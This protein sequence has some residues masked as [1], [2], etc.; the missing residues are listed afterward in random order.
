MKADRFAVPGASSTRFSPGAARKARGQRLHGWST[1]TPF[2]FTMRNRP[3]CSRSPP[4]RGSAS[5]TAREPARVLP[6]VLV[7][8]GLHPA[9]CRRR[10]EHSRSRRTSVSG[11]SAEHARAGEADLLRAEVAG[12]VVRDL[13]ERALE[14]AVERLLARLSANRYSFRSIAASLGPFAS[15]V[16][17]SSGYS[18]LSV[19]EQVGWIATILRPVAH[20]GS[21]LSTF[22]APSPGRRSMSP[23]SRLGMPQQ[24]CFVG[25]PRSG[26]VVLEHRRRSPAD[27]R[28]SL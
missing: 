4:D 1:R 27:A 10:P 2:S 15:G 13:A 26:P 3:A 22:C 25:R 9:R 14:V 23:P 17:T 21:R 18:F 7:V 11:T 6:A 20:G 28:A 16:P 5:S 12:H 24:L 19:S 8:A